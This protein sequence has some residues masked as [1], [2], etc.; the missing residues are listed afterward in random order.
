MYVLCGYKEPG[1]MFRGPKEGKFKE[2]PECFREK[3]QYQSSILDDIFTEPGSKD[4][5]TYLRNRAACFRE[6]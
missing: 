3:R 6:I 1:S 2:Q 5:R 4:Q